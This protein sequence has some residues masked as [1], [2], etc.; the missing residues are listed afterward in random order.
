MLKSLK[1]TCVTADNA[2]I[3]KLINAVKAMIS[4]QKQQATALIEAI[5]FAVILQFRVTAAA[6]EFSLICEILTCLAR[7]IVIRCLNATSEN[8]V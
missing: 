3:A 8:H 1:V 2:H 5:S 7:E 4:K 6:T